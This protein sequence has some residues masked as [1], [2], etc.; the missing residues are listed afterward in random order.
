RQ[1]FHKIADRKKSDEGHTRRFKFLSRPGQDIQAFGIDAAVA[2]NAMPSDVNPVGVEVLD[3]NNYHAP[4]LPGP[5]RVYRA[6]VTPPDDPITL[7]V[8]RHG[9]RG[10]SRRRLQARRQ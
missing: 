5:V 1:G 8:G 10:P 3:S 9:R 2:F 7:E 4:G 6:L